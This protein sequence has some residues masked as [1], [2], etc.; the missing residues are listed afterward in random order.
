MKH[1]KKYIESAKLVDKAAL[2]DTNGA[3]E[4]AV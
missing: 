4:L 2:Y 3:L 1:G